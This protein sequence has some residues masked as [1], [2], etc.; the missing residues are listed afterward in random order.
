MESRY[1]RGGEDEE[2]VSTEMTNE[3]CVP[4][5]TPLPVNHHTNETLLAARRTTAVAR[6]PYTDENISSDE[7]EEQVTERNEAQCRAAP[8]HANKTV[9]CSRTVARSQHADE[10]TSSEED[11]DKQVTER[12]EEA[13]VP[14]HASRVLLPANHANMTQVAA[15]STEPYGRAAAPLPRPP[16]V[17]LPHYDDDDDD[18]MLDNLP[19]LPNT[20]NLMAMVR[21]MEKDPILCPASTQL[22][23]IHRRPHLRSSMMTV[24]ILMLELSEI[25]VN[26]L[27][28]HQPLTL[29]ASTVLTLTLITTTILENNKNH[30][31]SPSLHLH[32]LYV[33]Y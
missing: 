16:N 31:F 30:S 14:R 26:M 22:P 15:S 6:S 12:Y 4:R 24:C 11:E 17:E 32:V 27:H 10:N 28:F 13:C 7:D 29:V 23:L 21:A 25:F 1:D 5:R 33:Y 3:A 18:D 20:Q 8:R 19:A 2:Q 9:L